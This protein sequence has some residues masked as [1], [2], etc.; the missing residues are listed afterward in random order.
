MSIYRS[1]NSILYLFIFFAFTQH[2]ISQ[3]FFDNQKILEVDKAFELQT[4]QLKNQNKI[5]W[6]IE[7][8]Y[9][10]YKDSIK[11][12]LNDNELGLLFL[13]KS[14]KY[15]DIFLGDSEIFRT[16]LVAEIK[17]SF[18]QGDALKIIFQGCA[19]NIY[20]YSPVQREIIF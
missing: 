19:E 3:N 2:L 14:E 16:E 17:H 6:L 12:K 20:C 10:L 18:R 9:F 5:V 13:T 15:A 4:T 7:D 1:L 11:I 8:N